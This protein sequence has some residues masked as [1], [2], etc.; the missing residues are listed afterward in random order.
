M[1]QTPLILFAFPWLMKKFIFLKIRFYVKTEG[2]IVQMIETKLT[3]VDR[4]IKLFTGFVNLIT[5]GN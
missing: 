5:A 2:S 3:L 1:A 4:D